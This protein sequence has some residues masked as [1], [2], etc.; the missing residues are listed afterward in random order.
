MCAASQLFLVLRSSGQRSQ[1][2]VQGFA[3]TSPPAG[4]HSPMCPDDHCCLHS[5]LSLQLLFRTLVSL[6][7]L[8]FLLPDVAVGDGH[9]Y[10]RSL[11]VDFVHRYTVRL[12]WLCLSV[13]ICESYRILA[14]SF[15]TTFG[16]LSS[17]DLEVSRPNLEQMF[18]GTIPAP[19]MLY[20]LAS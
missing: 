17:F 8:V 11:L 18:L 12:V 14:Q 3:V 9:I 13:S 15:S 4:G 7:F 5:P 10:H 16:G 2:L 20:L 1:M 19:C 6:Q